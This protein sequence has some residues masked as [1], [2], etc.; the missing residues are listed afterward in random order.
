MVHKCNY[1]LRLQI[2]NDND[3]VLVNQARYKNYALDIYKYNITKK[4]AYMRANVKFVNLGGY[5]VDFPN[6]VVTTYY[7]H[8]KVVVKT[9]PFE[10][11]RNRVIGLEYGT[12][13]QNWD[14]VKNKI[15]NVYPDMKYLIKKIN[16]DN[17]YFNIWKLMDL[18]EMWHEHPLEVEVLASKGF[19]NIACN[20]NLYKLKT[21]RKK[22][23]INAL[24]DFKED[25]KL[26]EVQNFLKS[27]LEFEEWYSWRCWN[28]WQK[29]DSIEVY[30][31]CKRKNIDKYRYHD[32]ISMARRLGH[33]I[34]DDYWRYPNDP[35][36][37][38]QRLLEEQREEEE[39][40]NAEHMKKCN[41]AFSY[42]EEIKNK[43]LKESVDLG[44]GY[45]L[46]IPS[47]QDEY[48]RQAAA[49]NQCIVRAEYY[50]KVAKG[51]S[52]LLMILQDGKPS[53][54]CE[55]D[56]NKQILQFYGNELD[57]NNCKPSE[58]EI[59]AMDE[60]LAS[61]KLKKISNYLQA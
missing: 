58:Y 56:Y 44:N 40:I 23:I 7:Y 48:N 8:E 19:Y 13:E 59:K 43:N 26:V 54:T 60:F 11:I 45:T 18:M 1:Y 3:L 35:N 36:A 2:E 20:K 17:H 50:L 14:D 29:G 38:H 6:E 41:E 33:N 30:R 31:Y 15:L 22:E 61:F 21:E 47:T 9:Y 51:K 5:L 52:L 25:V 32:I 16:Y 39:K 4:Q 55:I 10:K 34:E 27:G 24:K 12:L 53:S 28:S 57:R 46:F 37:M 42:L 49:L